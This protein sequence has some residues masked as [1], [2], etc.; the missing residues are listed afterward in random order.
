MKLYAPL[1]NFRANKILVTSEILSL[2][3]IQNYVDM[4]TIKEKDFL[5]KNPL[6]KIPVLETDNE[7]FIFESNAILR[8]LARLKKESGLY[9][10]ND[11]Q[12]GLVDQWLDFSSLELEPAI[13]QLLFPIQGWIQFCKEKSKRAWH[14]TT[15]CL[16][17]LDNHLKV[18]NYMVGSKLTI[19]DIALVSVLVNAFRFL[20]EEKFRKSIPN[21]T[22]WFETVVDNA[23]FQKVWGKIRLCVKEFEPFVHHHEK[24]AH[25]EEAKTTSP[26]KKEKKKEEAKPKAEVAKPAAKPKKDDDDDDDEEKPVKKEKNP[27]DL[28]PPSKFNL[29]DFKT[30][31]VNAP[32]KLDALKFFWENFDNEGYSIWFVKYIKVKGEGEKLFL[33]NNLMNG[34]LQRLE[35]FRK[36]AFAVH[37]VYG[38]EPTLEIRGVW[39]WRGNDHPAELKEVPA[40]EYHT[41]ER[42]DPT[43]EEHRNLVQQF[44]TGLEEGIVVDGLVSKTVKYFK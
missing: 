35:Q 24:Q 41:Y 23:A 12:S 9:G 6:G 11:F 25:A 7:G 22:R 8:Y 37:G 10:E 20:F 34:F 19:A 14:D 26:K 21:V 28:L 17:I 2:P 4:K 29:F 40:Y 15:S 27:L 43:K 36:Y 5:K 18:N 38:E 16:K 30:L 32:N 31:Y 39:V 13:L 33:T 44:W 1:G 3:I 42:L